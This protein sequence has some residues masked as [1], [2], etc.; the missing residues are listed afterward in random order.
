MA[1]E[2]KERMLAIVTPA[3][4]PAVGWDRTAAGPDLSAEVVERTRAKYVDAYERLTG[5]SFD[6]YLRGS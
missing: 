6:A 5:S 4:L 3:D 1:S 2:S